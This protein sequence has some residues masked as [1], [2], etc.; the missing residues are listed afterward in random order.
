M[1]AKILA[2]ET[3]LTIAEKLENRLSSLRL[4]LITDSKDAITN[5]VVY[6]RSC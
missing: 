6:Q 1:E 3:M 2:V 5:D 4:T